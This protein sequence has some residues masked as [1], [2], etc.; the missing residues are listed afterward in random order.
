MVRATTVKAVKVQYTVR[1][2]FVETNKENIRRVM[3]ALRADPI[4]GMHYATFQLADEQTFV[5][6]NMA[7]D[8]VTMD[9]F[10]EV[11]AFGVFRQAL[12]ASQPVSPPASETLNLVAAGFEL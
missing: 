10:S 9:R 2:E 8:Q 11:E 6:I 3:N 12:K 1:P 5:H 4:P 7:R